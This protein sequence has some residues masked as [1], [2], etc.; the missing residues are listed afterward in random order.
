MSTKIHFPDILGSREQ[1]NSAQ[2]D[3]LS[4][5]A[6]EVKASYGEEYIRSMQ[7]RLVNM[8]S[9]SSSDTGP[10]LEALKHAIL[11]PRPKPFYY[12][13]A[14]AW[15]LPLLYRHSPTSLSD[16]IFSQ[17]F[18]SSDAQPA[19]LLNSWVVTLFTDTNGLAHLTF[20]HLPHLTFWG[21]FRWAN[22]TASVVILQSSIKVQSHLSLFCK[23]SRAKDFPYVDFARG[24]THIDQQKA[25]RFENDCIA[26]LFTIF[27]A[28]K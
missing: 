27:L 6:Q 3:I 18:M 14:S 25:A 16:K 13:G 17:I 21:Q 10:F 15:A 2:E 19:E 11:S 12:P 7:Q 4:G 28:V 22:T 5:L 23:F 26:I 8:S 9:A 24:S 1:W 20:T